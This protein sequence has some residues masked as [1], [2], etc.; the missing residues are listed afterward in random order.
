MSKGKHKRKN[1]PLVRVKRRARLIYLRI[2]RLDDP[3]ERIAR[4]AAI[5][6][7]MGIFPTFGAG[8]ILSLGAAFILRA[9][10]AAAVI[11]SLIMN[12]FTSPFFWTLS[13]IVGSLL[14]REDYRAVLTNFKGG[15]FHILKGAGAVSMVFLVGNL[16]VSTA[17]TLAS[18]Y[19]VKFF[20]IRHRA[21]KKIK[22]DS[23]GY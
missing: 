4:G 6:V 23:T 14:L 19:L 15:H 1:H 3:P 7:F 22:R 9:N 17:F 13:V 8:T 10:K 12:P 5:G 2:M 20:I 21:R 18:Y 11:G 16:V